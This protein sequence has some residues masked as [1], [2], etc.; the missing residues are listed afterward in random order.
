MA[1]MGMEGRDSVRRARE[2]IVEEAERSREA[3][4]TRIRVCRRKGKDVG[5]VGVPRRVRSWWEKVIKA[6]RRDSFARCVG[7]DG[8]WGGLRRKTP[9]HWGMI[10]LVALFSLTSRGDWDGSGT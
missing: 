1:G 3:A 7:L 2:P 5:V 10:Q 9:P 4:R 8:D 6:G